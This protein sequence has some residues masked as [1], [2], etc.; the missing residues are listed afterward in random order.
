MTRQDAYEL[1]K[2]VQAAAEDDDD[3]RA[4]VR[5]DKLWEA[6]LTAIAAGST[7]AKALAEIALETKKLDFC[8]WCA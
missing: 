6:V 8:R 7:D 4:H 5:E 1:L 3:E 2:L